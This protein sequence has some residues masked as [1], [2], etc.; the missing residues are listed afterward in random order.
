MGLYLNPTDMS[1]DEWLSKFANPS[2]MP[3]SSHKIPGYTAVCRVDNV[4]MV[5]VALMFSQSELE[6]F[7]DPN[8]YRDKRWY[9]IPDSFCNQFK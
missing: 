8:D 4:W 1:K 6:A 2:F 5:A 7:S 9:W 3:P